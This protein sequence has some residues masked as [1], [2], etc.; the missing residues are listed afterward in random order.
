MILE[1]EGQKYDRIAQDFANLRK[2]FNTKKKYIDV[3]VEYLSPNS[4][5]LDVGCGSGHPI[6]SYLIGKGFKVTGVDSSKELLNIAQINNPAMHLLYGDIRTVSITEK[7]DAI[8]EW[9]CLFHLPKVDHAK[10]FS[11]F[12]SWLKDGGILEFTTG[13]DDHESTS[14]EM[15][16]QPL[17]FYSQTPA[18][19][20]KFLKQNGFKLLLKEHDQEQH[21]VWIAQKVKM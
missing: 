13:D 4:S 14:S 17:N 10:M 8:I 12:A 3:L 18:M 15:L 21:L 7:Y 11:R 9:W 5:I 16:D 1:N 20:E 6:A 19:Y 2:D